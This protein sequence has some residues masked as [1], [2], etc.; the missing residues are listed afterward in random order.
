MCGF[1]R[2]LVRLQN[3]EFEIN[4]IS[5]QP[6]GNIEKLQNKLRRFAYFQKHFERPPEAQFHKNDR[7][8]KMLY[9]SCSSGQGHN[10]GE[11]HGQRE[12]TFIFGADN[13]KFIFEEMDEYGRTGGGRHFTHT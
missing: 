9:S 3:R 8:P 12:N 2:L 6:L 5:A 13:R 4:N 10:G 1:R 7:N 11:S